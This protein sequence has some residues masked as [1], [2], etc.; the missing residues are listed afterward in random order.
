MSIADILHAQS[1]LFPFMQFMKSEGALNILQF[2]LTV[3]MKRSV[4][5]KKIIPVIDATVAVSKRKPEK[6]RLE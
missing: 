2:C 3:G 1:A 4:K 6:F 5:L